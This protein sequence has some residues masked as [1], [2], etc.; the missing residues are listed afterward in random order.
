VVPLAVG[1]RR[2]TA[3]LR[4]QGRCLQPARTFHPAASL[5]ASCSRCA[6]G[7]GGVARCRDACVGG[8]SAG[9]STNPFLDARRFFFEPGRLAA[10]GP[11]TQ[12]VLPLETDDPISQRLPVHPAIFTTKGESKYRSGITAVETRPNDWSEPETACRVNSSHR[13]LHATLQMKPFSSRNDIKLKRNQSI[14]R[15]PKHR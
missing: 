15:R 4:H 6:H 10:R 5:T 14:C 9:I 2:L 13:A 8:S 12:A 11:I 3:R 7:A 1:F